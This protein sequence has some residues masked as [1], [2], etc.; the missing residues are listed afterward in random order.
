MY[1]TFPSLDEDER[2]LAVM[3]KSVIFTRYEDSLQNG[4]EVEDLVEMVETSGFRSLMW[5]FAVECE[6]DVA[7][8]AGTWNAEQ[9]SSPDL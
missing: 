7:T 2:L 9:P 8:S 6:G 4:Q 1:D 5:P 3:K